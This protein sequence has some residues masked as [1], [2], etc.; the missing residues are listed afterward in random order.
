MEIRVDLVSQTTGR[1]LLSSLFDSP[2][3]GLT[4]ADAVRA[5]QVLVEAKKKLE[6]VFGEGLVRLSIADYNSSVF[7]YLV[8]F[9]AV[10]FAEDVALF[11]GRQWSVY[12]LIQDPKRRAH[13]KKL[14]LGLVYD[15]PRNWLALVWPEAIRSGVLSDIDTT[16]PTWAQILADNNA[17]DLAWWKLCA[18][19]HSFIVPKWR[20]KRTGY[21]RQVL[22]F[23][24]GIDYND[25][26]VFD[27]AGIDLPRIDQQGHATLPAAVRGRYAHYYTE[28]RREFTDIRRREER[29]LSAKAKGTPRR[30]RRRKVRRE[31]NTHAKRHWARASRLVCKMPTLLRSPKMFSGRYPTYL[32][33]TKSDEYYSA[34]ADALINGNLRDPTL[35]RWDKVDD[36]LD[37]LEGLLVDVHVPEEFS[38]WLNWRKS[39][40]GVIEEEK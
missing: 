11:A 13:L 15:A 29:M 6:S 24:Q 37:E 18:E 32:A 34:A 4:R 23:H 16:S 7:W 40:E 1:V 25:I 20:L 12:E 38:K 33:G 10:V 17:T 3:E 28:D 26:T 31:E 14:S 2:P 36:Y 9:R 8:L 5:I 39:G 21:L 30:S 35:I 22:W 27:L 19:S